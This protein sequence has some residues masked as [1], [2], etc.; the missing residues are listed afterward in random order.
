MVRNFKFYIIKLIFKLYL[1]NLIG[2]FISIIGLTYM[3]IK[4]AKFDN[5]EFCNNVASNGNNF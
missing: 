5:I 1:F 2:G 3:I 4:N